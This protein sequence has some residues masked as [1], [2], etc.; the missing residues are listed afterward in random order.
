[1]GSIRKRNGKFQVQVRRIGI[2]QLTKTFSTKKEATLWISHVEKRVEASK[3]DSTTPKLPPLCTFLLKYREEITSKKKGKRQE[4]RRIS[5]LLRDPISKIC[6]N[7]LTS[8]KM[9]EFRDRRVND[10][11]RAA[12]IDLILI[13]HCLKIAKIEWGH[14]IDFNPVDGIRI[15][16]GVK[17]R[18]RRLQEG[19]LE[20]LKL[21]SNKCSNKLIWPC[22]LFA[23]ETGMRRSEILSIRWTDVKIQEK[24]LS[25]LETKNGTKREVPLT[26]GALRVLTDF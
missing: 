18:E 16:N 4:E 2:G 14:P 15:P 26:I 24:T 3:T 19:E 22:V 6:V 9:A 8:A 21:A 7:D 20:Q 13:R 1:M 17:R 25:I 23:I 10:G 5:R 12:Q 11:L